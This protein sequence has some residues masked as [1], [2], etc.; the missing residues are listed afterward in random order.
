MRII[1]TMMI[2]ATR[3][4]KTDPPAA[5]TTNMFGVLCVRDEIGMTTLLVVVGMVAPV[6]C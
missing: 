6:R 2:A 5:I 4:T 1:M 3:R